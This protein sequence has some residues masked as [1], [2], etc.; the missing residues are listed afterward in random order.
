M[1]RTGRTLIHW[2]REYWKSSL[3]RWSQGYAFD[4]Y[5][6]A[7]FALSVC[8]GS[9]YPEIVQLCKPHSFSIATVAS[10]KMQANS[11]DKGEITSLVKDL[12]HLFCECVCLNTCMCTKCVTE[13]ASYSMELE[14]HGADHLMYFLQTKS[15]SCIRAASAQSCTVVSQGLKTTNNIFFPPLLIPCFLLFF[16]LP[17]FTVIILFF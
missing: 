7:L 10:D 1:I 12:I 2:G 14:L 8:S 6:S 13:S 3:H 11:T 4:L 5:H 16:S 9:G 17:F 15:R